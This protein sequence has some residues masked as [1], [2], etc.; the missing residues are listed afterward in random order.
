MNY[1]N[2]VPERTRGVIR[3]TLSVL[4]ILFT[5]FYLYR[6]QGDLLA[7]AQFVFSKGVTTY[8]RLIGAVI[9]TA[10]LYLLQWIVNLL[11]R[12]PNRW[13]AL[14]FFPSFLTLTV[15]TDINT[16]ILDDFSFGNWTWI[17]PVLMV[18]F[19]VLMFFLS[20]MPPE[21]TDDADGTM[22]S[23][24]WP[25]YLT[26]AAMIAVSASIQGTN[27]VYHYELRAETLIMEGEYQE[28]AKVGATSL[29]T[30]PRLIELRAYALSKDGKLGDMLF[31]YPLDSAGKQLILIGDSMTHHRFTYQD[32]CKE[33][34]AKCGRNIHTSAG[35]LKVMVANDTL[36]HKD[37]KRLADYYL[38]TLL[39]E[40][41]LSVFADSLMAM[42][43]FSD[44]L[45]SKYKDMPRAYREAA[46]LAQNHLIDYI[47]E[48]MEQR[49]DEYCKLRDSYDDAVER[50]NY[51]RRQFGDTYWWYFDY[52]K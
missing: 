23:F 16:K 50:K 10:V 20:N 5:F 29:V 40:K 28:A 35:Y 1:N 49:Y 44:S 11:T 38:C 26:M 47:D 19:F 3:F 15:L 41:N 31:T 52:V 48:E 51:L 32:I 12:V 30:S 45:T 27:D 42:R 43:I 13:Y 8:H 4:F 39:M 18:L 14:T 24:L 25:N 17:Y 34:G 37:E 33:L 36:K 22:A 21:N 46:F 2:P 9:I 7:E 6:I